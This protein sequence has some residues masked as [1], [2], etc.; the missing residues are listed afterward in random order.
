MS[1]TLKLE[2]IST[3]LQRIAK[4]ARENP[5]MVLLTLAHHVDEMFLYEA[6]RRTRKDGASGI[7]GQSAQNYAVNLDE[8]IKDLLN[9]FKRGTYRAPLVRRVNIP[10]EGGKNRPIDIP[11]FEDKVLQR[12]VL[13]ILEAVYEEDFKDFSYGFRRGRSPHQAVQK[14][15]DEMMALRGGWVLEADISDCFGSLSHRHIKEILDLRVQD[16]VLRR[17]LHKWLRAGVMESGNV[18]Y[19]KKGS[20]QGG[21]I[22]PMIANIYL[23]EVLDKWFDEVV[24]PRLTAPASLVRYC[25]DFVIVF[26]NE[27]DA[28]RVLRVLA[29]RFAKY[30]LNIHP[31]KTRL[32]EFRQPGVKDRRSK[33]SVD[34]LGF[35]HYWGRSRRNKW[36]VKQKTAK[37]RHSRAIK[38]IEQWCRRNLHKKVREQHEHLSQMMRGHYNYYGVTGNTLALKSFALGV[39]RIWRKWL[40]RR[41]RM[42]TMSWKRFDRLRKRYPLPK[43]KIIHSIYGKTLTLPLAVKPLT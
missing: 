37:K 36:V 26:K 27:R 3:R 9:Q 24:R 39:K 32:V 38:A 2:S 1:G 7:D 22:S 11:T 17:T 21:V 34:F 13:M 29:K 28:Q 4:L 40:D 43:P 19:P 10:K 16:G 41:S 23:H 15:R 8:N 14:L 6:Y 20:P 30:E 25:D 33:G 31:D 35:T 5:K 42:K 12:A 18:F